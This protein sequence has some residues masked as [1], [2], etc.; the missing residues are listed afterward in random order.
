MVTS[1]VP[2]SFGTQEVERHAHLVHAGTPIGRALGGGVVQLAARDRLTDREADRGAGGWVDDVESERRVAADRGPRVLAREGS[3]RSAGGDRGGR[4]VVGACLGPG[5]RGRRRGTSATTAT[6]QPPRPAAPCVPARTAPHRVRS[7]H[8]QA[9]GEHDEP[10]RLVERAG[11]VVVLV[12]VDDGGAAPRRRAH[13]R[14]SM[15]RARA[16]PCRRA[17]GST[18]RRWTYARGPATPVI[19]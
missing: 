17:S 18:A 7:R 9:A 1:R 11:R 16:Y 19:A 3:R 6:P 2:T 13:R 8:A 4:T 5:G 15:R 10:D 12:G 14:P